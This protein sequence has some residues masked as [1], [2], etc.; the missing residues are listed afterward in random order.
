MRPIRLRRSGTSRRPESA[1]ALRRALALLAE[2]PDP[3]AIEDIPTADVLLGALTDQF[4]PA[5]GHLV[6]LRR[7]PDGT[8]ALVPIATVGQYGALMRDLP[9]IDLDSPLESARVFREQSPH[10]VD[11]L[12]AA[13]AEGG[14]S[15]SRWRDMIATRSYAVLP[16]ILRGEPVGVLTLEWASAVEFD[17]EL[18]ETLR[19]VATL[20]AL[21]VRAAEVSEGYG[22]AADKGPSVSESVAITV[23]GAGR[24][25]GGTNPESVLTA[26]V[27]VLGGDDAV[28]EYALPDSAPAR[29]LLLSGEAKDDA[30]VS[31]R[32]LARTVI[33]LSDEPGAWLDAINQALPPAVAGH[34]V[35]AW[36]ATFDPRTGAITAASAGVSTE[37]LLTG[38]GGESVTEHRKL[39]LGLWS[40]ERYDERVLL[41]VPSDTLDVVLGEDPELRLTY[42]SAGLSPLAAAERLPHVQVAEGRVAARVPGVG[43]SDCAQPPLPRAREAVRRLVVGV[44]RVVVGARARRADER[45][46]AC[47]LAPRVDADRV[48]ASWWRGLSAPDRRYARASRRR[49]RGPP[50]TRAARPSS[51]RSRTARTRPPRLRSADGSGPC[52][53]A[54]S[55]K[56]PYRSTRSQ[57]S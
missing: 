15:T 18:Q 55:T 28:F 12:H 36:A 29:L 5:S 33:G 2:G 24:E 53:E 52:G 51:P 9:P 32:A 19:S 56:R 11:E 6:V 49:G 54:W 57:A 3:N 50:R 34:G 26:I 37:C 44:G 20:A 30:G 21:V 8:D 4:G 23:T 25:E 22:E 13:S 40:D 48:G 31:L 42:L 27:D 45:P 1:R 43:G 17:D 41:L 39:P 47:H 7:Q 35:T 14:S 16:L 10:F 38:V 46:R